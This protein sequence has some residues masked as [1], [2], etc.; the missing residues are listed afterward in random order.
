[1]THSLCFAEL[2]NC[3]WRKYINGVFLFWKRRGVVAHFKRCFMLALIFSLVWSPCRAGWVLGSDS[4]TEG[5]LRVFRDDNGT[6]VIQ[7]CMDK[8]NCEEIIRHDSTT[9]DQAVNYAQLGGAYTGAVGTGLLAG[10]FVV[11]AFRIYK[12]Y[13]RRIFVLAAELLPSA[14]LLYLGF[15]IF[16]PEYLERFSGY[17]QIYHD[18]FLTDDNGVILLEEDTLEKIIVELR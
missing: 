5:M 14:L 12:N 4:D 16:S 6:V 11:S 2:D 10:L 9:F 1:M 15:K 18:D 13:D 8:E 17:I 3:P 7:H